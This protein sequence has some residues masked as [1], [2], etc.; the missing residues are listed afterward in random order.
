MR[1]NKL[2]KAL[3]T[4]SGVL[5]LRIAPLGR[6]ATIVFHHLLD[7]QNA[8]RIVSCHDKYNVLSSKLQWHSYSKLARTETSALWRLA[9]ELRIFSLITGLEHIGT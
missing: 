6:S 1:I 9:V 7:L 2:R 8:A 4:P 5:A 3:A